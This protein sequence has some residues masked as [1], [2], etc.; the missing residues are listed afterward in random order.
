MYK[1]SF[2]YGKFWHYGEMKMS[3]GKQIKGNFKDGNFC[4]PSKNIPKKVNVCS[5]YL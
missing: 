2:L 4:G 5:K 3:D 1:G